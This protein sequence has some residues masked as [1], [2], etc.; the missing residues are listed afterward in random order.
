MPNEKSSAARAR[1]L[2]YY[3]KYPKTVIH[4]DELMV[5]SGIQDWPRRIRELRKEYGWAIASGVTVN[6]MLAEDEFALGDLGIG[7]LKPEEYIL[8]DEE[9]A[10]A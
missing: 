4:G 7:S 9:Q 10:L 3:R 1:I 5:V 2:A 6:E 8:L